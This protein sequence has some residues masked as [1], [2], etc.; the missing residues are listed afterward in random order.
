MSEFGGRHVQTVQQ[1]LMPAGG[2]QNTQAGSGALEVAA[3]RQARTPHH[4]HA[5][6]EMVRLLRGAF[7]REAQFAPVIGEQL[8]M[9][10]VVI[11]NGT[12]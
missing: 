2:V 7:G 9:G 5:L 3:T 6:D 8:D 10:H 1:V 12:P 11:L 4:S